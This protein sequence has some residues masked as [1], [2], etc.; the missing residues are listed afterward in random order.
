MEYVLCGCK[1][2]WIASLLCQVRLWEPRAGDAFAMEE[3]RALSLRDAAASLCGL[4]VAA[5]VM[6]PSVTVGPVLAIPPACAV[7]SV[8][9]AVLYGHQLLMSL[10]LAAAAAILSHGLLLI[11][12][13][14]F[15]YALPALIGPGV[16]L[17]TAKMLGGER[18][19]H[20]ALFCGAALTVPVLAHCALMTR[21]KKVG[22]W[23]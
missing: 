8:Q 19:E 16:G 23:Q 9:L 2:K 5:A 12:S 1:A 18:G 20:C 6:I 13:I 17:C 4:A 10:P 21:V 22:N 11:P 15:Q 3:L 14:A 7:L